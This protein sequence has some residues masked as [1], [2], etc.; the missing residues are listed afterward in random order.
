MVFNLAKPGCL[1]T[2]PLNVIIAPLHTVP[3]RQKAIA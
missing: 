2:L 3:T 1:R